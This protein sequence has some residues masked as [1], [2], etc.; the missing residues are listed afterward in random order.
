MELLALL[1][2]NYIRWRH[3]LI[4]SADQPTVDATMYALNEAA[5][6]DVSVLGDDAIRAL[7]AKVDPMQ[8]VKDKWQESA[9]MPPKPTSTRQSRKAKEESADSTGSN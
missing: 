6:Q 4:G 5:G 7:F 1:A 2:E 8:A 9:A 3:G